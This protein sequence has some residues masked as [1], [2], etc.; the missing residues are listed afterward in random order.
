MEFHQQLR[1]AAILGTETSPAEN[2]DH[3]MLALELRE[4]A[5]LSGVVGKFVIGKDGSR[6][7]VGSHVDNLHRLDARRGFRSQSLSAKRRTKPAISSAAVPRASS[8]P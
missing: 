1:L 5:V 4:F 8:V 6:N 2:E 7:D 3:G